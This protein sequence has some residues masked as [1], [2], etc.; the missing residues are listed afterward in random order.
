[1]D[2][3]LLQFL[4][5]VLLGIALIGFAIVHFVVKKN[6]VKKWKWSTTILCTFIAIDII[7]QIFV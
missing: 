4:H 7:I 3:E 2:H 5:D 1:M 6:E